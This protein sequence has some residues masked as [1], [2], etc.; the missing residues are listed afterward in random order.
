MSI[1][2][3]TE[4][5]LP[6][7][8]LLGHSNG[9]G[10]TGTENLFARYNHLL[11][12]AADPLTDPANAWYKN[13][14]VFTSEHPWPTALGTPFTT[15]IDQG[16]WLELCV[17]VPDTP[18]MPWP[19][20]S[21]FVYPNNQGAC[22]AHWYYQAYTSLL[23]TGNLGVRHGVEL[24]FQ[25]FWRNHWNKQVGFVKLAF[26]SSFLLPQDSGEVPSHWFNVWEWTPADPLFR[27]GT[28]DTTNAGFDAMSWW[29]PLDCWDF[30]P[31]TGRF[32]QRWLDKMGGAAAAMPTGTKMDVQL[33]INWLGDNDAN[34]R[35]YDALDGIYDFFKKFVYLQ[36]KACADNDWTTLPQDQIPVV[37]MNIH[38]AYDN[39][40]TGSPSTRDRMNE[41]LDQLAANDPF[42]RVLNT[43]NYPTMGD[44][45]ELSAIDTFSHF[46]SRG[47]Y[48]AAQEIYEAWADIAGFAWDAIAEEDRVTVATV[49]DR[50]RTYYNRARSS[51]DAS[52]ATLLI[53]IN[54]ALH[55]ILNSIGDN[56]YWLR[57]RQELDLAVGSNNIT[58]MPQY[59]SRV[60][61]IENPSR[62]EEGLNFQLIGHGDGGRCQIHLLD[63]TAG[64]YTVHFITRPRDV[65]LDTELVPIPRQITE[66][67][68]VETVRRLARAGTNVAL[69]ASLE[70][71]ARE[72]RERC[73]KELQVATRAKRD[74][75]R[76]VK[77]WP[78]LR[79]GNRGRPWGNG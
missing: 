13:V 40:G 6:V 36:R 39:D 58:T 43:E 44:D 8:C 35:Q 73:L 77:R 33:I 64:T 54:A 37:W 50:V 70:G 5:R 78:T 75:F 65:T 63:S 42:F 79:Y 18:E 14:Y 15:T 60:L 62:I 71:E 76:T 53:H 67:L 16:E 61:K 30:A 47:Y 9:D 38:T 11:P 26:G 59:V 3:I 51:T 23:L 69:Q 2:P 31:S 20:P 46:G 32:F 1:Y 21:P 27:R 12:K 29:S 68:V 25:W 41:A 34:S 56:A 28:V 72:L 4:E 66:W 74:T 48:Q 22:Y 7:F 10:W 57:R 49:K 24:P 45:G 55:S 19:H 17:G 52:D